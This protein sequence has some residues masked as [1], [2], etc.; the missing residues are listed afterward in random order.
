MAGLFSES[1]DPVEGEFPA[2]VGPEPARPRTEHL[3][4]F[5]PERFT[6]ADI[7]VLVEPRCEHGVEL[8]SGIG[9]VPRLHR[10]VP[11]V[12]PYQLVADLRDAPVDVF[13][14]LNRPTVTIMAEAEGLAPEE[15]ETL[16]T[17]PLEAAMA[18]IPDVVR[19][20]ST[21]GVG[22]S[23]VY[24]EFD[25]SSSLLVDRQMVAEKLASLKES[26][27]I[28]SRPTAPS[29]RSTTC[30]AVPMPLRSASWRSIGPN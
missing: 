8:A 17:I 15:A 20:R 29:I 10:L 1:L 27:P 11:G 14:D 25:W 12:V 26:R 7:G 3:V 28:R 4:Y 22:L 16:V 2:V 30:P 5:G 19:V 9:D 13:P 24:V 18:G 21:S 23:I 6:G